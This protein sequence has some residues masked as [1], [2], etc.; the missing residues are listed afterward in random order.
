MLSDPTNADLAPMVEEAYREAVRLGMDLRR[1]TDV[2]QNSE[3]Y[4]KA[5]PRGKYLD[6]T[7]RARTEAKTKTSGG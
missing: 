1:Y 6:E 3:E 4:E 2:I 7:R 5:F